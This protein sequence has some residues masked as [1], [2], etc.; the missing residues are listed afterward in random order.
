MD[1]R[2]NKKLSK[3]VKLPYG[4]THL[5]VKSCGNKR[6]G[7]FLARKIEVWTKEV[8]DSKNLRV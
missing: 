2:K 1:M 4:T 3:I 7:V 8:F 6:Y 5:S